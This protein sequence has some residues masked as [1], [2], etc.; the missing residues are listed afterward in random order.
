[1]SDP[2]NDKSLNDNQE[3]SDKNVLLSYSIPGVKTEENFSS[4][5]NF[6][7][8]AQKTS[9][10]RQGSIGKKS[11]SEATYETDLKS[12]SLASMYENGSHLSNDMDTVR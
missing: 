10:V 3:Y 11:G 12:M 6:L 2:D 8:D 7:N 1:M 9:I 4:L 5:R